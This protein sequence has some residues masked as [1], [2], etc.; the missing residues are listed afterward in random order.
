[1]KQTF[2]YL[3]AAVWDFFP[4][5]CQVRRKTSTVSSKKLLLKRIS[6]RGI[7]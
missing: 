5:L 7:M 3:V 2:T 6:L 4:L 1:M